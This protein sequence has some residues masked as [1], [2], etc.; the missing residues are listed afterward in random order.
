MN[1]LRKKTGEKRT[2]PSIKIVDISN[3]E[4][5]LNAMSD[6]KLITISTSL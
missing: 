4:D 2:K 5:L 3:K 6:L 1:I